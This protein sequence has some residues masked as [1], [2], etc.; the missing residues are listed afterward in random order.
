MSSLDWMMKM[1]KKLIVCCDGTNNE[2]KKHQSN[3]IKFYRVLKK[4]WTD[5]E[6]EKLNNDELEK[7]ETQLAFYDAGVGTISKSDEWSKFKSK[8]KSVFS[9]ATGYGLDQNVLDAYQFLV[10]HYQ[11]GDKICLFAFSRGAYTFRVLAGF[12]H[13]VDLMKP[14]M[15]E[16]N[17]G[18]Q[19]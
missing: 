1:T 6:K 8:A 5:K 11:K 16:F 4:Q 15:Q 12:I 18:K 13:M 3:V 14:E 2:I 10:L 17:L 7:L 9:L 19:W